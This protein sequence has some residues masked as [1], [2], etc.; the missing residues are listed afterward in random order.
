MHEDPVTKSKRVTNSAGA[1]IS[2]IETDPWGAD[3]N[4]SSNSAFQP[5][6]FTTYDRD[7]NGTDEAM[8]R[9]YNRW[10]SRFDQPDPYDGSYDFGNPQSFNRYAYVNGDPVNFTDPSGLFL[11]LTC[12]DED[13]GGGTPSW[14]DGWDARNGG[15]DLTPPGGFH[16]DPSRGGG[17]PQ[18]PAPRDSLGVAP[19][20]VE[21][22]CQHLRELLNREAEMGTQDAALRSATAYGW[23]KLYGL[24]NHMGAMV[25]NNRP[26][27]QDWLVNL[28]SVVH[29][30]GLKASAAAYTTWKGIW[31]AA[32]QLPGGKE[33][34][35]PFKELGEK[36]AIALAGSPAR[37][38]DIFDKRFMEKECPGY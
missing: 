29:D 24:N 27:D 31:W 25:V 37:F 6:K 3:T 36:N 9:R 16:G 23:D 10:Q 22:R 1:V 19:E 13:E 5:K 21:L 33:V 35:R 4:R 11:C 17:G 8:F 32:N 15:P 38:S 26:I 7:S 12:P 34:S 2:M 30:Q 14:W 20:N 18:N 28:K